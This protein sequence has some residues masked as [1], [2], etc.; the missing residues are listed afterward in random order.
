MH[1]FSYSILD[2]QETEQA[3]GLVDLFACSS[4]APP[5]RAAHVSLCLL[6]AFAA[7]AHGYRRERDACKRYRNDDHGACDVASASAVGRR[8]DYAG[9]DGRAVR[10]REYEFAVIVD[11][12]TRHAHAIG[13]IRTCRARSTV[14]AVRAIGST[15][16]AILGALE[17]L[18][19]LFFGVVVFGERLTPRIVLGVVLILAAVTLIIAGRSLHIPFPHLRFR[20][21]R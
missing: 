10:H 2:L 5:V 21:A 18:T 20:R 16:T 17:P 1:I 6:I 9:I 14:C 13:A 15:P 11:L 19:A 12:G 8:R 4:P 7:L 3:N